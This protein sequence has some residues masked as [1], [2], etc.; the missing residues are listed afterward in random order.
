MHRQQLDS[1]RADDAVFRAL[2]DATRRRILHLVKDRRLSV[3]DIAKCF[4][5]SR[6]AISKHLRVL[7]DVGLVATES[8]GRVNTYTFD[9]RPLC[10]V[11]SWLH[12]ASRRIDVHDSSFPG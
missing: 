4:E 7:R 8:R 6:P 5:V 10:A 11:W 12:Q 2:A 1:V 9:D 3:G